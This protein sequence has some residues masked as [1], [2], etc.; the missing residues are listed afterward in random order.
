VV[1]PHPSRS[2]SGPVHHPECKTVTL[3]QMA[4]AFGQPMP[5]GLVGYQDR[6]GLMDC[7][8]DCR[9]RAASIERGRELAERFGW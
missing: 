4:E 6:L 1:E 3:R 9:R 8:E 2:N 5:P 7:H